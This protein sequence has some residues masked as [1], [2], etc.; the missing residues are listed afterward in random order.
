MAVRYVAK[1]RISKRL[2]HD[3]AVAELR[4]CGFELEGR[5]PGVA[6][7]VLTLRCLECKQRRRLTLSVVRSGARCRHSR[8]SAAPVSAGQAVV[9]MRRLGYEPQAPYP[10]TAKAP[11]AVRC[12]VCGNA[13]RIALSDARHR[14]PCRHQGPREVDPVGAVEEMRAAG[15]EP[16]TPYPGAA[17]DGWIVSCRECGRMRSVSLSAARGGRTCAHTDSGRVLDWGV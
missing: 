12:R 13:R 17:K 11:W 4:G 5:Y 9:E 10:G 2:T 7:V 15:Y 14:R 3:E 8:A 16:L 6:S 1:K